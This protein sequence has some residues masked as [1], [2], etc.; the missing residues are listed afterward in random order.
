[1]DLLKNVSLIVITVFGCNVLSVNP[2]KCVSMDNQECRKK[3]KI[4]NVNSNE[5][6]FYPDSIKINKCSGS[7]NNI[8]DSYA[9]L[10]VSDVVENINVKTFNLM[11]ITHETRDSK[12]YKTCKC[13]CRLDASIC[14]NKQR[15]NKDKCRCECKELIDKRM[16]DKS[17]DVGE[18]LDY[19]N[20][21]CRNKLFE[22]LLEEC[23][24]K[25]EED[26]M[27]YNVTL[28]DYRKVCNSCTI[29]IVLFAI[30]LIISISISLFIYIH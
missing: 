26:E 19:N 30:F 3:H 1:M 4:I 21:K 29:D 12:W 24:E 15:S 11:S 13:K 7:C 23:S 16:C 28:N 14:N 17:C 20:C 8:N 25:T 5:P 22:K 9:K 2:L 18:Y 6:L 27:V 10:C